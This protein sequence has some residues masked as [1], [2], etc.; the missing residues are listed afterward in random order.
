METIREAIERL[1]GPM[2]AI[3]ADPS[4]V[5]SHAGLDKQVAVEVDRLR[6]AYKFRFAVEM[7]LL[8]LRN[9]FRGYERFDAVNK[10]SVVDEAFRVLN[11]LE[12]LVERDEDVFLHESEIAEE[13][14]ALAA[15]DLDSRRGR[16]GV[17]R[18][19]PRRA[20]PEPVVETPD[21]DAD[22]E[23]DDDG[24]DEDAEGPDEAA[25]RAPGAPAQPGAQPGNASGTPARRKRR[26]RRGR[27]KPNPAT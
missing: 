23:D 5:E 14:K 21:P 13:M 10:A 25:P 6:T 11:R 16:E 19:A 26:R 18:P 7:L 9:A 4:R 24:P 17:A 2:A 22:D 27:P 1:K 12:A 3:L 8:D 15:R 20:A